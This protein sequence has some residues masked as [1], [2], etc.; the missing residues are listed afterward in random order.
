M[1]NIDARILIAKTGLDGHWRWTVGQTD[2]READSFEAAKQAVEAMLG[3]RV[4]V[5]GARA[6]A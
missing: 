5:R 6:A 4:R 1:T 3:E 2:S